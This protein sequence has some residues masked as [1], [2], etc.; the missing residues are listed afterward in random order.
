VL[1]FVYECVG[2]HCNMLQGVAVY[3]RILELLQDVGVCYAV[4][5][6]VVQLTDI[7]ES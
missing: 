1:R 6:S 4:W 5:C 2:V 7:G 3:C